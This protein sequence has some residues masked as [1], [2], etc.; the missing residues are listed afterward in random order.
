MCKRIL[1]IKQKKNKK[2]TNNS[3]FVSYSESVG[4]IWMEGRMSVADMVDT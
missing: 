4:H 3:V 1:N 2:K